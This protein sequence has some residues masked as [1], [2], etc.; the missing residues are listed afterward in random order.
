[1]GVSQDV[2]CLVLNGHPDTSNILQH[3]PRNDMHQFAM[4]KGDPTIPLFGLLGYLFEQHD[5]RAAQG[6]TKGNA[7]SGS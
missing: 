5:L 7:A 3:M 2:P 6:Q 4:L 1:M